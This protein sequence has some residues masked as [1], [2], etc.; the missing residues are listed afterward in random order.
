MAGSPTHKAK[1]TFVNVCKGGITQLEEL[2]RVNLTLLNEK[3]IAFARRSR[4][5]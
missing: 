3:V 4:G 2:A 5:E 1:L